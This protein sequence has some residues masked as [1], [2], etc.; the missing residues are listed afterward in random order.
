MALLSFG[1]TAGLAYR[2]NWD[3][4]IQRQLMNE[5]ADRQAQMDA[6]N[7]AMILGD[8]LKMAHASNTW[9]NKALK[10]FSENRIKEIG[11]FAAENPNFQNDAGLWAQF[12]SMS[13]ELTNND[14]VYR[15][16]R[17][18]Q[19]YESLVGYM[20]QNPGAENDP[21]IQQ[22][23]TE[24]DNYVKYGSVDGITENGKEFMFRNPDEQFNPLAATAEAF[25]KLAPQERYAKRGEGVGIGATVTE[26]PE[27]AQYSTAVG[28]LNG[29]DGWRY[30]NAWNNMSEADK[31]YYQNDPVKWV[32]GM[33]KAYT[34]RGVQAGTIFRPDSGGRGGSGTGAGG[35]GFS[36][37]LNDFGRLQ[38][39]SSVYA[40]HVGTLLPIQDGKMSVNNPLRVKTIDANGQ[41][42]WRVINGYT[43]T[44]VDSQATGNVSVDPSGQPI[45]EVTVKVPIT[46]EL[47]TGD[48]PLINSTDWFFFEPENSENNPAY[49]NVAKVETDAEGNNTGYAY[50]KTW[51]PTS[52][53]SGA[54]RA[55]DV[56]ASGVGNAVKAEG[57]AVY[58][59]SAY[60]RM[61]QVVEQRVLPDGRTLGKMA[62]GTIID[63]ATGA[64]VE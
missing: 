16:L 43:G 10:E 19:N 23:L 28:L 21:A 44:I 13:D 24:Y 38:P 51:V 3:A 33:G 45:A 53:D 47:R 37:Y 40:P 12:N 52:A 25:S 60:E 20:Q 8:K 36:P 55:Y 34:A 62:D 58:A 1:A 48:D 7:K 35:G 56:A 26:V 4:E 57:Q 29:P 39:G 42:N 2:H 63:M 49:E 46:E 14:I 17:I 22:Q 30:N 27:A 6:Q 41:E 59:L 54:I 32:M 15:S 50:I 11:R 61:S 5:Q 31:S 64:I 18:Q 9:D